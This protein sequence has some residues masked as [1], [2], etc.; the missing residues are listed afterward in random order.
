M[1]EKLEE[2]GLGVKEGDYWCGALLYADDVVLL[3]ESL[4][5][6]MHE[7]T[8]PKPR[9]TVSGPIIL[10]CLDSDAD[11]SVVVIVLCQWL[12]QLRNY[13]RDMSK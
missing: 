10:E 3:A 12:N 8:G 2:E 11:V 7:T 4:L 1:V 9:L 5:Q 6:L 13:S